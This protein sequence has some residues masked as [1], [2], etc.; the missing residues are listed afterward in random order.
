MCGVIKL[1]GVGINS[2]ANTLVDIVQNKILGLH[3]FGF[4]KE[5]IYKNSYIQELIKKCFEIR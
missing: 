1:S 5:E 3:P 4:T 2:G